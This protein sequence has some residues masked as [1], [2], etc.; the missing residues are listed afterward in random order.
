MDNRDTT[1]TVTPFEG[2]S[3]LRAAWFSEV[4]FVTP[5]RFFDVEL[6]AYIEQ[7]I[8]GHIENDGHEVALSSAFAAARRFVPIQPN[9]LHD[10][11][12]RSNGSFA[13]Q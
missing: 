10:G 9:D 8:L 5:M 2:N 12:R 11:T 6:A 13:S 7:M 3:L 4:V 1:K